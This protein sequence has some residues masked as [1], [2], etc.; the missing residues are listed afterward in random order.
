[1]VKIVASA[2]STFVA[3]F[4]KILSS[5]IDSTLRPILGPVSQLMTSLGKHKAE[6]DRLGKSLEEGKEPPIFKKES[7]KKPKKYE[8]AKN[9]LKYIKKIGV[10]QNNQIVFQ[11]LNPPEQKPWSF[12]EAGQAKNNKK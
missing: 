7:P 1:M 4:L 2:L 9:D 3:P 11:G 8:T 6:I 10:V 12:K 5:V